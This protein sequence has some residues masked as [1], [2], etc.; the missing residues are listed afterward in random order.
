M[1]FRFYHN[2]S[3]NLVIVALLSLSAVSTAKAESI[4]VVVSDKSQIPSL[5]RKEVIDIFMGRFD[6]LESGILVNP[7][8]YP[9]GATLRATFYRNLVGKS[10]QQISAYWSRLLF[11]GRAK[12][13][14]IAKSIE[15]SV[16]KIRT[17]P[18]AIAYI[19]ITDVSGE[20]KIVLVLE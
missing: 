16:D 10:E 1:N 4:A 20:M 9:N 11:S 5:G 3:I 14:L 13:P 7:V 15:A 2:L 8:D 17:D 19:P 18:T 12:P 6:R